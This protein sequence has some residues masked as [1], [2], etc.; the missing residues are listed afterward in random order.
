MN[1]TPPLP[2]PSRFYQDHAA[3]GR[4]GCIQRGQFI[5]GGS[6][7]EAHPHRRHRLRQRVGFLSAGADEVAVRR[8]RQPCATSGPS[9]R[10]TRAEKF[11]VAHHYPHIDAMLAG[12][13]FDFLDRPHRHAGAREAQPPGARS[14]QAC[15]ERKTDRQLARRRTGAAAHWP[16]RRSFG[17]GARRSPCRAR[18]SRSWRRHSARGQTR[19]RRRGARRLRTRRAELVFVLLREGRRQSCRT[20]RFTISRRSPACS[21]R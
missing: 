11:K 10:A 21:A 20:W 12:E 6:A 3:R 19:P 15:L 4:G 13:P 1:R 14:R 2:E 17:C 8:S 16:R 18:S 7:G 5:C 9:A